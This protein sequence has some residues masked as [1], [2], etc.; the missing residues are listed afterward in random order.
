MSG[1][2]IGEAC[3]MAQWVGA[4]NEQDI[5]FKSGQERED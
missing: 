5:H 3:L 4:I 1:H 2:V